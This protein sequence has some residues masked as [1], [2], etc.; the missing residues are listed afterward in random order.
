MRRLRPGLLGLALASASCAYLPDSPEDVQLV[1][2]RDAEC[3]EGQVCFADGCGDP[4]QNIVVEVKPDPAAGLHAQ[5]FAVENLRPQH[6]L[7]L[8]G[9]ATLRGRVQRQLPQDGSPT[10]V[11]YLS[12]V[13]VRA[14]G[15][16]RLIPGL[17]RSFEGNL[18]PDTEGYTLAVGSGSYTVTLLTKDASI[19]PQTAEGVGVEPGWTVPLDFVLPSSAS[20]TRLAGKVVGEDN[21]PVNEVLEIQALDDALKPLSQRVSVTRETGEFLLSLPPAAAR[22]DHV[23]IQVTAPRAGGLFPQREFSVD[24]RPGVTA[25]L[26]LE[27]AGAAVVVSGRVVDRAGQP[28]ADAGVYLQG[29]VRGGGQFHSLTV[30]TRADGRFEL[31]SLPSLPDTPLTLY[32][33]PPSG[34]VSG[35]TRQATLVPPG[36]LSSQ[37]VVCPNK[38]IVQGALLRPEGGPAA[39]VKVVADPVGAVPGWPR[40]AQGAEV[41]SATDE[42]GVYSLRL[43]PGEYRFD[44]MPGEN[45]PR[46]SRF[47]PVLAAETM[48]VEPFTLS[49]GRRVTGRVTLS[50]PQRQIPSRVAPYADIQ[51]FRVVNVAGKPTAIRL[52]QTVADSA[53]DYTATL[54][55]R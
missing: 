45:L 1:C 28:V 32:A 4:G 35:I 30:R 26:V 6:H 51:F 16:S 24:P 31:Q 36:G 34:A 25:P 23:L 43:D 52:A 19:P 10:T 13:F 14:T 22:L 53:G 5:D 12:P 37:E 46:V 29:K 11:P 9:P 21:Q 40:P 38:V 7:E 54:P 3:A 8:F 55:T 2:R 18:V 44:F 41:S 15:E 47:V 42:D 48:Q 27:N 20:L 33:I 39:G 49:K 50:D 17:T